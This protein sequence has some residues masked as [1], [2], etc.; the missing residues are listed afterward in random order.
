PL[1]LSCEPLKEEMT[2]PPIIP[3]NIPE[4]SGAPEASAIPRHNGK[5]TRKTTTLAGKS[6]FKFRLDNFKNADVRVPNIMM[7]KC[8]SKLMIH[9][10][11]TER[12][13]HRH[14]TVWL[15]VER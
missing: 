2:I 1:T 10:H 12:I 13:D 11:I 3:V 6:C 14:I 15:Y 4:N 9:D 5:A 8:K 7:N